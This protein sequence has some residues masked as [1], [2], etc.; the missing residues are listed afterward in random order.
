MCE[1]KENFSTVKMSHEKIG[2]LVIWV[3]SDW[4]CGVG[5]CQWF[6]DMPCHFLVFH[7][8]DPSD[9]LRTSRCFT[10]DSFEYLLKGI[11]VLNAGSLTLGFLKG[12]SL[13]TGPKNDYIEK[14]MLFFK[15]FL[16]QYYTSTLH[17][18]WS[19]LCINYVCTKSKIS[20]VD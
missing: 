17:R 15:F 14:W 10:L 9:I 20:C 8:G 4:A 2:W 7:G 5:F 16:T 19:F 13:L 11:I 1:L 12:T 18:K 6:K 3:T